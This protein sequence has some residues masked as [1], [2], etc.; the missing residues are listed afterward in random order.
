MATSDTR[1]VMKPGAL[2]QLRREPGV[3]ADLER[4]GRA[5]LSRCGEAAGYMM[6]SGQGAKRPQGR[7]RVAVFTA[8]VTAMVDNRRHNTLVRAFGAA[9]G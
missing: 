9:R 1:L 8:N 4:R 5:V 3:R 6:T 2:Y 7:W